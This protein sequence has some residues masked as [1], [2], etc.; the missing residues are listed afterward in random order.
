[1]SGIPRRRNTEN[2]KE[3]RLALVTGATGRKQPESCMCRAG[4]GRETGWGVRWGVGF[5]CSRVPLQTAA[6]LAYC[7]AVQKVADPWD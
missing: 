2:P 7:F 5:G 3:V 6:G 1:M 4:P